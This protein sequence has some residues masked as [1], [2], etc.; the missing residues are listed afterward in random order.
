ML[1]S[2]AGQRGEQDPRVATPTG[3]SLV[4]VAGRSPLP[5]TGVSDWS[6][7]LDKSRTWQGGRRE[8]PAHKGGT[9]SDLSSLIGREVFC[10]T[11]PGG[12]G[13]QGG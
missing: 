3:L 5:R 12:L 8:A 13:P 7:R 9:T 6:W 1:G 11:E 2:G 4:G 10:C